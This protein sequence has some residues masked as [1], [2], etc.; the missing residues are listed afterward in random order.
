MLHTGHWSHPAKCAS[1]CVKVFTSGARLCGCFVCG[2]LQESE[3]FMLV[4]RGECQRGTLSFFWGYSEKA[5]RIGK[6]ERTYLEPNSQSTQ[7]IYRERS[8]LAEKQAKNMLNPINKGAIDSTEQQFR[9]TS[10]LHSPQPTNQKQSHVNYH[11]LFMVR[12]KLLRSYIKS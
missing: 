2:F 11:N 7:K 9:Q 8:L 4:V 6:S 10:R 5:Q 12:Q 3:P 1:A